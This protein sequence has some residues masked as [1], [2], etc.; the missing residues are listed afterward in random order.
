[1]ASVNVKVENIPDELKSLPQWV[2]WK[3]M[4]RD[5][6]STKLPYNPKTGTLAD[7]TDALTWGLIHEALIACKTHKGNGIGFV[8]SE[9]DPYTGIDLDKCVNPETG[10]LEACARRWVAH[11]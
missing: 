3:L 10:E 9:D 8:F 11:V 1:M 5:G 4:Q 2:F 6:K 7:S